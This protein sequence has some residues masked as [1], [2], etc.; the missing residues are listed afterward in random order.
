M[1]SFQP[2]E[3]AAT[4]AGVVDFAL[5]LDDG[6]QPRFGSMPSAFARGGIVHPHKVGEAT[7]RALLNGP[8]WLAQDVIDGITEEHTVDGYT[9][10][11][12]LAVSLER[13]LRLLRTEARKCIPA[14]Q[15]WQWLEADGIGFY[16]QLG[17]GEDEPLLAGVWMHGAWRC[18]DDVLSP[19]LARQLRAEAEAL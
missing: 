9:S 8:E 11:P 19:S 6:R 16:C 17:D 10:W 3:H 5:P 1:N 18:P 7:G 15:D 4:A 2:A 13:A 14:G 12:A